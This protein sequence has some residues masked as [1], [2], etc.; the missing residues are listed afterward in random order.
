M[1]G[2]HKSVLLNEVMDA[3]NIRDAW[4]LDATLGDGG[5]S[6]EVIKRG[7]KVLG[8]D[9]DPQALERVQKRFEQE[10]IESS[11][12]KLIQGNF[13]DLKNLIQ[14]A[15]WRDEQTESEIKFAG[16]I[17]DL[18]VSSMQLENPER[19][20]SFRKDGPL[21]MRMDQTFGLTAL[22]LINA[23]GRKDLYE[24]FK[25]FGEEKS[26]WT[27][28]DAIVSAREIKPFST[29][30]D[31]ANLIAK[32]VRKKGRIPAGHAEQG[33]AGR[34]PA[35]QVFQALR[36][37]VNDE[38]GSLEEGLDQVIDLIEKNGCICVIS[39]HSLEDRICKTTFRQWE[40]QGLGKVLDK[41]P[42]EPKEAEVLV[43]PRS[44]S[45][46]LRVFRVKG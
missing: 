7:G 21:D 36:I 16:I 17:F 12:F 38:L 20:F 34:H 31:L 44:R 13:R 27:L 1:E 29:T 4:Y 45:A 24:L 5:H 10:G 43:N 3:L 42:L 11:K 41:K 9:Q 35:T 6:I 8:I 14:S 25:K 15:K 23:G 2:Y 26:A 37:A 33:F 30:L 18:G 39:F 22:D 40:D 32:R 46:K 28:A 19:G